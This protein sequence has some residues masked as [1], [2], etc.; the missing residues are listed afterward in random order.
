MKKLL[1]IMTL[2]LYGCTS[3]E[4]TIE[5][6]PVSAS[7]SVLYDGKGEMLLPMNTSIILTMY[8]ENILNENFYSYEMMIHQLHQLFD[9]D[10]GFESVNNL[11]VINQHYG[12]E[13]KVILD[14]L[15]FDALKTSIDLAV[16]SSGKFNPTIGSLSDLY[17]GKFSSLP[18]S[19]TD[20]DESEL[21]EAMAC[22]VSPEQLNQ[23]LVLDESDTSIRFKPY[24]P[25]K[26]KVKLNLGAF[27]KG[28]AAQQT[29]EWLKKL[30]VPFMSACSDSSQ[31][32]YAPDRYDKTWTWGVREPNSNQMLAAFTK[33][34][35]AA[36]S[37]SGD[38][39]QYYYCEKHQLNHHHILDP[40]LGRSKNLIRS[41]S[42]FSNE[43]ADILDALTTILFNIEDADERINLIQEYEN[44]FNIEIGYCIVI[45]NHDDG[46]ELYVNPTAN[47]AMTYH[48]ETVN[49]IHVE[50]LL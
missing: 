6:Q 3:K 39:Q 19:N 7:V 10:H 23:V 43:R 22:V 28:F 48:A 49:E 31:F 40:T 27:A 11:Y 8:D 18:I 17:Q 15:L 42:V 47:D 25:C 38:D 34:N 33:N 9:P 37:T 32:L 2:I 30:D 36:I 21:E 5:L 50:E 13:E 16:S 24:A 1:L 12:T 45:G 41:V 20:P 46:Y 26:Q 4:E 44:T 14:P 35:L 29:Y